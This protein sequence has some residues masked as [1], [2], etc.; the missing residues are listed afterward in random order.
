VSGTKGKPVELQ[1]VK[2]LLTGRALRRLSV[3]AHRF[4]P[5][6][7]CEV[8]YFDAVGDRYTKDDVRVPVWQKESFGRGMVCYCFGENEADIRAET[9]RLG[10]SDAVERVR[11]HIEAGRCACEV[12]NPRGV[13]C[14]GDVT[15]AVKRAALSLNRIQPEVG[16]EV[17]R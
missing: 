2:A 3:S 8:V 5:D 4:C 17:L 11:R 1:T 9:E 15:A 14:L 10:R 12:R 6:P 13:C 7:D 16:R